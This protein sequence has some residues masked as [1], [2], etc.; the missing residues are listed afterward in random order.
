MGANLLVTGGA[1]YIGSIC[2]RTLI[3][4]GHSVTTIDDL[5]TGHRGAVSGPFIEGDV[6]DRKLVRELFQSQ[7]F[8]AVLH[9]AARSVV[10]DSVHTPLGYFDVNVGGTFGLVSE[11]L[12][13]GVSRLVFS[14]TCAIYGTPPQLPLTEDL[15]F[16]P[17]SPYGE[18][19]AMVERFLELCRDKEGLQATC[20]RYFNAAGAMPDGSLGEAHRRETH[21]IPLAIQ[22]ALG[23]RPPL[24]LFGTDYPTRDG[25]CVRDYI[26]VLDLADAH[27]R[28][29]NALLEGDKGNGYNVGTG[30]GTTVREVIEAVGRAA[31]TPVPHTAAPRRAGDPHSLYAQSGKIHAALGWE[32]QHTDLDSIVASA[33]NWERNPRF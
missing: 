29:V 2:A 8:D 4:A 23:Q 6:R 1:G 10:G 26:H 16:A 17:V 12:E 3:D 27:V 20:L 7:Q 33:V 19:K 32:P 30:L 28:A 9:F 22:A 5:T 31:G 15:P 18:T 21:L 24:K 11:M 13:A 25:T 14:S